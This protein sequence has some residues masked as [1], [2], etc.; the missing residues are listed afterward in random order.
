M[1]VQQTVRVSIE[2]AVPLRSSLAVLARL[3]TVGSEATAT[4]YPPSLRGGGGVREGAS[5]FASIKAGRELGLGERFNL[6]ELPSRIVNVK[7]PKV[8]T[9]SNQKVRHWLTLFRLGSHGHAIVA[10]VEAGTDS[11][12]V[13]GIEHGK[14][15]TL[16]SSDGRRA[17][18]PAVGV[19]G[20]GCWRK[21]TPP[22][23]RADTGCNI[24]RPRKRAD[25]RLVNRHES[26]GRTTTGGNRK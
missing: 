3:V 7:E 10:G 20:R 19:S 8:L 14:P 22:C 9:G 24:T 16:P 1:I 23:N 15:D 21:Q 5:G 4:M 26:A 17:A 13:I 25:F 2:P 18:R 12:A 11:S 6:C